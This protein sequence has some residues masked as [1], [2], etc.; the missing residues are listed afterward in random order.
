MTN[1][2]VL[3]TTYKIL[4]IQVRLDGLSFFTQNRLN[5]EVL[6]YEYVAFDKT[7][8]PIEVL[9][10]IELCVERFPAL[11]ESYKEVKVLFVNDHFTFVP[12]ALFDDKHLTD[13]L[14]FNTKI[15]K[16]D[17]LAY[18][19]LPNHDLVNVYVP[20]ANIINYFFECYG[21][22]TY[23]H[24]MTVWTEYLLD[25]STFSEDP[26]VYINLRPH[27]FDLIVLKE[28]KLMLANMHQY[29]TAE[30]FIYYVLFSLEQL[31]LSPESTPVELSG[32]ITTDDA[33]Y[34]YTYQ[35]IRE[36]SIKESETG[37]IPATDH[38][39]KQTVLCE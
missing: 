35:Y 27:N 13:Y 33:I 28:R 34:D 30:D 4:S 14:K 10:Q 39:L 26:Q 6:D 1:K 8:D 18:D 22:F 37:V 12:E 19:G 16:T 32:T 31:G 23:L 20:Y 38:I 5:K 24:H 7:L 36:V 9:K 21:S 25:H 3:N 15:L 11:R 2:E 29:R 17:Y